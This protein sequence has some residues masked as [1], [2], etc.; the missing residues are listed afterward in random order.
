MKAELITI[1][2]EILIGQ[3]VNTNAVFLAKALNKIGIEVV[4]ITSIADTPQ[5]I[6]E[7]L[8]ASKN[9]A[10]LALI[11]GG[12]GPTKDDVTKHALCTYFD[13]E[14]V[15]KPDI[16][17]HIEA[18]FKKYVTTP[19]QEENR[20]QALLPAKA[21]IFKNHHGT[22]SGMWF[23]EKNRVVISLP[24]V[25]FEMKALINDQV[26]PALKDHFERP[27]ILHKTVMTYGLGESAIANKIAAW[28]EALPE[29]LKLAYLPNL[30]KVRLRLSGKGQH[31]Q[32]LQDAM[33][34]EIAK[35][36]PLIGDIIVGIE[37]EA[38]LEEQLQDRFVATGH[39]LSVAESCTG[40]QIAQRLTAI[41]GA[42]TY[43][44]GGVVAYHTQAKIDLLQVPETLIS[45]YSV[46]SEPVAKAMAEGALK[47]FKTTYALA[48]TG[49]AGPTKGDSPAEVGTV[50]IALASKKETQ[51][52]TFSMGNHRER[53]VQKTVNKSLELLFKEMIV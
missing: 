12:L 31:E 45:N 5:A 11:T 20:K 4:Q 40:G 2:D 35:L 52:F 44:K 10:Q 51:T 43:F 1:G 49:N 34:N 18:I 29:N 46:V 26:I 30:G 7:A 53:V 28:E 38:T 3:I 42:S 24:G 25:P 23:E 14:L 13:D 32:L 17:A 33:E 50:C 37:G 8:E 47:Q 36:Y 39:T 15:E 6:I 27:Y 9:R 48:T 21:R 41:P 22:A 16:L 19:I